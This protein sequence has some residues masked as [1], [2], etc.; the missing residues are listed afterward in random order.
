MMPSLP[1]RHRTDTCHYGR[2][3]QG[4]TPACVGPQDCPV[5]APQIPSSNPRSAR[6]RQH[7]RQSFDPKP[8]YR[9]AR[10]SFTNTHIGAKSP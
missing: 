9:Q 4:S 10:I 5:I 6:S 1:I 3:S 8:P 2:L 7:L